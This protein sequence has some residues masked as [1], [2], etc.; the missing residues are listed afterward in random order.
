MDI[1]PKAITPLGPWPTT[2]DQSDTD[3]VNVRIGSIK[4]PSVLEF[5]RELDEKHASMLIQK[6]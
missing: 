2:P 5:Q 4:Y 6:Q 3:F 1:N